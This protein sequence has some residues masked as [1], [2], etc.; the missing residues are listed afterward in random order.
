[1]PCSTVVRPV[2]SV[3]TPTRSVS[4]SKSLLLRAEPELERL[5]KHD[6]NGR[7]GRDGQADARERRSQRQVQAGLQP[8]GPRR[9]QRRQAFGQQHQRR[10]NDADDGFRH[11]EL[12]DRRPPASA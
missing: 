2:P 5:A 3:I 4:A 12:G 7:D 6:R 11:V 10:D 8:V 1:M 9:A